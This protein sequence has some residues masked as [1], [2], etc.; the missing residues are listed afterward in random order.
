MSP[1]APTPSSSSISLRRFFT[2]LIWLCILPL[3]L[4]ATYLV[5]NVIITTQ[6]KQDQEATRLANDFNT[7]IEQSLDSRIRAL[8]IL[9]MSPLIEQETT[10]PALY[11]EAQGFEQSFGSQVILA[12]PAMQMLFNT[13]VPFGTPLP[14]LPV[15][16]G[17]AAAPTALAT[18]QPA[19]SDQFRGP[20]ANKLLVAIAVPVT[21]SGKVIALLLTTIET[22]QLQDH[23]ANMLVPDGWYLRL[24]DGNNTVM[25]RN[26]Q[27]DAAHPVV[28]GD[29][30]RHVESRLSI[31]PWSVSVDISRSAY[32]APLLKA[33][34]TLGVILLATSLTG[35]VGGLI[36][37]RRLS[38]AITAIRDQADSDASTP[39]I[40][41]ITQI[42]QLVANEMRQR[43]KIETALRESEQRFRATFEQAA[44]GLALVAPSGHW[45]RV[46]HRL[47]EIVGYSAEELHQLTFQAIT[48]PEDLHND[49]Q[50]MQQVLDR[51][52]DSYSIQKR[53]IRKN[54]SLIWI[55]LTVALI[56]KEDDS[57]DY[58]ISVI[59]DIQQRITAEQ[60][61]Q[62]TQ[63]EALQ[64]QQQARLAALNLME[65]A[66]AARERLEAAHE[67]LRESELKYRLLAENASDCIFWLS[68]D[69][70]FNYISPA[71][72]QL[73]GYSAEAFIQDPGLMKRLVLQEDQPLYQR[74][75]LSPEVGQASELEFRIHHQDHSIRWLDWHSQPLWDAR[76]HY[77]GKSGSLRDITAKKQAELE[78]TQFSEALR[79]SP[80]PM[81]LT[82]PGAKITYVNPA[83][84]RLFG[85]S[86]ADIQGCDLYRII[87]DTPQAQ[88][89]HQELLQQVSDSGSWSGELERQASDGT[90]IPTMGHVGAIRDDQGEIVNYV[91][92]YLDLRPLREQESMLRKLSLAVE[93]SP[94]SIIITNTRNIIEYVNESFVQNTGFTREEVYGQTPRILQSGLT[95]KATY[96]AM[97]LALK[98]G[99]T[100]HGEFINQRRDGSRYTEL[101]II[102]PIR[103]ADGHI[104]H[105]V[106]VQEDITEKKRLSEELSIHQHHLEDLVMSRTAELTAARTA[107]D[108]ANQ[109]KSSF[110][111]N[112]SHEIRTPMNAIIG[113]TYLLRQS[114]QNAEQL[115]R[116]DKIDGS[117]RHLLS[118]IN[119][120][121][122][123]SKIEAGS[124]VLEQ[125]DFSLEGELDHVRSLIADQ[126]RSKGL[127]IT[128]DC[129]SV[130]RWLRGDPTRIRQALL[131]YVG[132]AV[133]FT[134]QGGIA[135]RVILQE[136]TSE[137]LQV[138]F[139]VEDSG[140]GIPES[141]QQL[142]FEPFNQADS[143]TTRR[144]GGT[145]LGLAITRRLARM[146][147]GD[148]GV[149]SKE[150][151]GSTFWFTVVLQPG[152][153][154]LYHKVGH[155]SAAT[156]NIA[157]ALQQQHSGAHLLLVEDNPINREIALELLQDV[158]LRVDT[159]ENGREALAKVQQ[160]LYSLILMDMQMPEMDGITATKAIRRLPG[161]ESLPIL[162]MTANVF[163]SDR[164][165]CLKAGM[166]DFVAK[167]VAPEALYAALLRWMPPAAYSGKN[168][169]QPS[170]THQQSTPIHPNPPES[171][172][173][174]IH[175][176]E[177]QQ[178]QAI[179]A[180]NIHRY[181][182]Y[183]QSFR[184][185]HQDDISIIHQ[186]LAEGD[187]LGAKGI[188]H[189]IKGVAAT[190]GAKHLA[191]LFLVL[192]EK[193]ANTFNVEH[194]V[195]PLLE[196][197]ATEL[198]LLQTAIANWEAPEEVPASKKPSGLQDEDKLREQ[199][200]L[201]L[202]QHNTRANQLAHG[203]I[204]ELE[205]MLDGQ[206]HAFLT[207]IDNFAYERARQML[208]KDGANQN[209]T[210][211]RTI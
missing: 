165:R 13:R 137:H 11:R 159:A 144:F 148:A 171:S 104:S 121:L 156:I 16:R 66:I 168:S 135:I 58:F 110:L 83:F 62:E 205:R 155:E 143:S 67:A 21:R 95:P 194:D 184:Y 101:A 70:R 32:L 84:T 49:L 46:N 73:S 61:V 157:Q 31:A 172:W 169:P 74:D 151:V 8:N 57:P 166:N 10:W 118:I 38:R 55:N 3:I 5:I 77:L 176:F 207:L 71:C 99:K 98:E 164:K 136:S 72:E 119:D 174:T 22:R 68:P 193:L 47:C 89:Q 64:A 204:P 33:T 209:Q 210:Q 19:V 63:Q 126:A 187:I 191:E 173:P 124:M 198:S 59:E 52:R 56:R 185:E 195:I 1:Q 94:E 122:D 170:I 28:A 25:A 183:L 113:L 130:P 48:A 134:H 123:L 128:T 90:L 141:Q 153:G 181:R 78:R 190:L 96:Q 100:W 29:I 178:G 188:I 34:A 6:Q 75:A 162:A 117:A 41:E 192:E 82:D 158:G 39:D 35:G 85:Y 120:I 42:R 51:E 12:N 175:G 87:P 30:I 24:H 132:N 114:P 97:T 4:L 102:T 108:A 127:S 147:G 140:I 201:L 146:M 149:D 91:S 43:E 14:R 203:A 145:G 116:L 109:A 182:H 60:R 177:P 2:R 7:L 20:V 37:S 161:W 138:R 202:T 53:Y 81:L 26:P 180:G 88:H 179:S 54:G 23:I 107:A 44:V 9:A 115:D 160:N 111:A 199:L 69:G 125:T 65:D 196:P 93:Q 18:G 133:K 92:N 139:E 105:Y 79:Q 131:N 15:P 45:I 106:A 80:L 189:N 27:P 206:V 17:H 129:D 152:Q 200:L 86:L 167:P 208:Q 150:G 211:T 40:R 154:S 50:L 76:E 197:C 36:A 186:K 163:D 112:M 142:L 103:Q